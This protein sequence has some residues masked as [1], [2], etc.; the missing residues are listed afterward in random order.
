M[1]PKI[2]C[3]HKFFRKTIKLTFKKILKRLEKLLKLNYN[4]EKGDIECNRK[5]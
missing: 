4:K 2:L 5:I 3:L 1:A